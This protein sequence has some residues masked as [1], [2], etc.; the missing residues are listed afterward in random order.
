MYLTRSYLTRGYGSKPKSKLSS[1]SV[2]R[3]TTKTDRNRNTMLFLCL[4]KLVEGGVVG[5]AMIWACSVSHRHLRAPV[6][7][8]RS[9]AC[10]VQFGVWHTLSVMFPG[11]LYVLQL[12]KFFYKLFMSSLID[13]AEIPIGVNESIMVCFFSPPIQHVLLNG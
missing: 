12:P 13:C 6:L 5:G 2:I 1:Y 7:L 9:W 4:V 3:N 10:Y 8:V 11:F